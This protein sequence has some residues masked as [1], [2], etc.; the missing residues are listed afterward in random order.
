[1]SGSIFSYRSLITFPN[2]SMVIVLSS[3]LLLTAIFITYT[4][5]EKLLF[6]VLEICC[7]RVAWNIYCSCNHI[8]ICDYVSYYG[9]GMLTGRQILNNVAICLLTWMTWQLREAD[10]FQRLEWWKNLDLASRTFTGKFIGKKSGCCWIN[11]QKKEKKS[12]SLVFAWNI[13]EL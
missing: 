9:S 12:P 8:F 6:H 7:S 5:L 2:S 3:F 10:I 4:L 13:S 1:M 11:L